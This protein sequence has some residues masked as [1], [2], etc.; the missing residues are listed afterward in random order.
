M[1]AKQILKS[2]Q[3]ERACMH[4]PWR[5]SRTWTPPDAYSEGGVHASRSKTKEFYLYYRGG[6]AIVIMKFAKSF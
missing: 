4:I 2:I 6:I 3:M 5:L 1:K